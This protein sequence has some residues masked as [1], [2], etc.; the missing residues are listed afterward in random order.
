VTRYLD[1]NLIEYSRIKP[2]RPR[3][4]GI[5]RDI[6]YEAPVE[7]GNRAY[8][9]A[10]TVPVLSDAATPLFITE[11]EKKSLKST[12][13]GFPAVGLSGVW[14]WT[15]RR[16]RN[17]NDDAIGEYHLI[18]DLAQIPW[19]GRA[20][21]IVFDSDV[22]DN[23][24]VL[25]AEWHLARILKDKG[26]VVKVVRLP[27]GP[28]GQKVGLDDYL[29]AHGPDA[30]RTL[31]AD[32]VEPVSPFA[33]RPEDQPTDLGNAKRLVRQH[34]QDLRFCPEWGQW[35]V[36]DGRRWQP[37]CGN[38][39]V[40]QRAKSTVQ[41]ILA[42]AVGRINR[43]QEEARALPPEDQAKLQTEAL[44]QGQELTKHA[45]RS[46]SFHRIQA[47]VSLAASEPAV[48]VHPN[49]L[50]ANPLLFNVQN[51]TIDLRTGQLR[52]HDRTDLLTKS[53]SVNYDPHAKA[54]VWEKFLARITDNSEELTKFLQ[55]AA[56]YSLT[57]LVKEHALFFCYGRGANGKSTFL[58]ALLEI[59]GDYAVQ[60]VPELLTV[61][62]NTA[63]PTERA[64]LIGRRLASC[65]ENNAGDRLNES[66][67]KQLTGGDR[68][69]ARKLYQ[70]NTEFEPTHKLWI[71]GN[72]RPVV[73]DTTDSSWRRIHLVPF[74]VTIAPAEMDL[75]L[76]D[77]LRVEFSGILTW[78]V[79]GCRQW[80]EAGLNVPAAVKDATAEY[81]DEMDPL[82]DFYTSQ[83]LIEPGAKVAAQ[84]LLKRYTAWASATGSKLMGRTEFYTAVAGRFP[85]KRNSSG[86]GNEFLGITLRDRN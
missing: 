62:K 67:M 13:E 78:M 26:A 51:G 45:Q 66:L 80:L 5:G 11:G 73:K 33:L 85:R 71:A 64:D 8:F 74:T 18:N 42:E 57:G 53:A 14:S 84:D 1:G 49:E 86:T 68:I 59:M 41:S 27:A 2:C 35:F 29:V 70:D 60:A 54:P 30:F 82:T 10:A 81:R 44:Q 21:Y 39:L 28:R 15:K 65:V 47:M 75:D 43:H 6:K 77:K 34:G 48:L 55:R 7:K 69:R 50:D 4:N 38:V 16:D 52:P 83:C 25:K 23:G 32:A 17:D 19:Q 12:Q 46:Q 9:P 36:W 31:L 76:P 72:H 22:A 56:G 37:D 58:H 3:K 24:N 20:V 61:Q 63:H 79:R 40:M